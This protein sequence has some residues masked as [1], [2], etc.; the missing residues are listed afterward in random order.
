MTPR[1]WTCAIITNVNALVTA[2]FS[3]A[4]VFADAEDSGAEIYTAS[5]TL[6]LLC[7]AICCTAFRSRIAVG[8]IAFFATLVQVFDG[9]VGLLTQDPTMRSWPFAL[10]F[11]NA[12]SLAWMY[13]EHPPNKR[14]EGHHIPT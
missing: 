4:A 8:V 3:V 6:A 9:I 7:V 12:I 1:F 11:I 2:T 10:A 13:A 5:H 14:T